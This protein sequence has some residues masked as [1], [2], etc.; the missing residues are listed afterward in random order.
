MFRIGTALVLTLG[1]AS[2]CGQGQAIESAA[3]TTTTLSSAQI[4]GMEREMAELLMERPDV[5]HQWLAECMSEHL[6]AEIIRL[7]PMAERFRNLLPSERDRELGHM[8]SSARN[9]RY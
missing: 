6:V 2:A 8:I 1:L 5:N 4:A 9:R 3:T 7:Q